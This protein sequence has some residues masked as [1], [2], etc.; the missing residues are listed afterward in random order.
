MV[1]KARYI[2]I[3]IIAHID[4]NKIILTELIRKIL[5]PEI[6]IMGKDSKEI[7]D[8]ET[9]EV[10]DTISDELKNPAIEMLAKELA[11]SCEEIKESIKNDPKNWITPYHF[12]WGMSIRNLLRDK[13]FGEDYFKVD[14]LDNIYVQLVEEAMKLN[15]D[16]G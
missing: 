8:Y 7:T 16:A 12:G 3:G 13:G 2:N 5:I 9:P 6:K 11:H 1:N 4:H 10:Y 15:I 14:N